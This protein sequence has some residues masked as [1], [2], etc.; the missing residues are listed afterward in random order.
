MTGVFCEMMKRLKDE[1]RTDNVTA[2][3]K[4]EEVDPAEVHCSSFDL[5]IISQKTP[6]I[7]LRGT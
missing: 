7:S 6:V 3:V 4:R 1:Q 5:F 2:G